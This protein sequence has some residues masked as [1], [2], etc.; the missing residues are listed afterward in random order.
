[1]LAD[2]THERE[3]LFLGTRLRRLAE[4]M[5]SDVTL[6]AQRAGIRVQPGRYPLLATLEANGGQT[7]G[8]L[9]RGLGMSQ[10]AATKAVDRLRVAGLV[11]VHG[12]VRDRRQ[13][14]IFLSDTG[15]E[16]LERSRREVW[17][18]VEAAVRETVD[19]L[20]GPL[21]E[22]I[23]TIE[24]RMAARL[25]SSRA[26]D[27]VVGLVPASEADLPAVAT[28]MNL[29]YR[30]SGPSASW[31]HEADY[32]DGDRT[33]VAMLREDIAASPEAWLL[34]WRREDDGGLR[35][36]VWLEPV[37]TDAWYLGS[38]TVDPREQNGGLGRRLLAAA[39]NS[40]RARA[41]GRSG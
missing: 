39:G 12:N 30:S 41:G 40:I 4:Q 32:L 29:A 11:E 6:V 23:A 25:L 37:G 36:C 1:M 35:G 31:T 22:Q 20:S 34:L 28:L 13:R 2:V 19:D 5:Q 17:P 9:A 24:A 38:L 3:Y 33:S 14:Q 15:R 8:A 21:L 10:P 18:L 7:I 26:A 16:M 27:A